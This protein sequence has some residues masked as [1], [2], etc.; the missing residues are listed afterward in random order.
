MPWKVVDRRARRRGVLFVAAVVLAGCR[1]GLNYPPAEVPRYEGGPTVG[2]AAASD[3]IDIVSFNIRYA[4]RIDLAIELLR[5]DPALRRGDVL[6]LNEMDENGTWLIAEALGM[7]YVYYPSVLHRRT[8]RDFGNAVLSRWPI[9]ED[10]RIVLP[11]VARFQR[12]QRTATAA[13]LRVGSDLVRVYAT[14]LG[15][16]FEIGPGARREQL[17]TILEDSRRYPYAIIG[18]DMNDGYIGTIVGEYGFTWPTQE[19]PRTMRFGRVDHIFV[20]N[21]ATPDSAGAGT[22]RD[23]ADASDHSPVWTRGVLTRQ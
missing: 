3:T 22:V 20:K 12:T 4:H 15:T 19:G 16:F 17:R 7:H 9:V 23:A 13:T 18:G 14:H 5:T 10:E 6:L 8:G 2:A 11:H 21:L 1:T